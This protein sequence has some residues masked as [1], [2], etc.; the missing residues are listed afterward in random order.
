MNPAPSVFD[1]ATRSILTAARR[2][3]LGAFATLACLAN[4]QQQ[5]QGVCAQAK[6]EILQELTFERIGFEATLE[7]TNNLGGDPITDF[8]AELYF[9]DPND[10][11]DS[12]PRDVSDRFF[13]QRPRLTDINAVDG[14]GLIG[15]TKTAIIRWFIVPK[16]DAGGENPNGKRYEVGVR[17][18]G[19]V[20][21]VIL[22]KNVLVAIPDTIVVR[23]EPQLDINYF[24][25]RDVQGDDPFTDEVE[26]AVPFTLG[27]LVRN[28][29]FGTARNLKIAS[30]Q[31]K[32]IENTAG[33][34]LVAQLLGSR[35][36]DS[37]LDESSLTVNLGD[38][39]P[40]QT[41]KGAW[42]M[43]TTLSGEFTEFKAS[44]T[45]RDDLGGE[46]TSLIKS[47][48]AHFILRE[49]INNDPGR[50]AIM[51][52]IADVDRDENLLPDTLYES[53]GQVLPINH[54]PDSFVST[55][56]SGLTFQVTVNALAEGWG[57]ARLADPGQAKYG[58]QSAVRSD[59]R[60]VHPRNI[61]TNIRY[62][63]GTNAKL[64]FLNIFDKFPSPGTYT[65]T[66]TYAPPPADTTP[67]ETRLRF[68]GEVTESGG[69]FYITP[70]TQL[71]FTSDDASPVSIFYR[72]N[73][74]ADVPGLPFTISLPGETLIEYYAS[75]AAGNVEVRKS[76]IVVLPGSGPVLA[77]VTA[78]GDA[79]A[80]TEDVLTF[81]PDLVSLQITAGASGVPVTAQVDVFRG[82]RSWPTLRG[83]PVTPTPATTATITV[84]GDNVD[85]YRY[86]VNGGA[87]SAERAVSLPFALT[88]LD[89]NVSV[90]VV[91]RS[92]HAS[93]P[94]DNQA[95]TATWTVDPAAAEWLLGGLPE[96]PTRV[97][98]TT[99]TVASAGLEKYRWR[100]A[101]SFYRA[102]AD[103]SEALNFPGQNPGTQT[104]ELIARRS[105]VW[106]DEEEP[107]RWSWTY[108][109]AHGSD[110]SS[111][112]LVRTQTFPSVQGSSFT[113]NWDGRS[114]VGVPQ[115][116]GWYTVRIR[117]E[118]SL[119]N[120]DFRTVLVRVDDVAGVPET[121]A[122]VSAG[123]ERPR[124][125]GDWLVW[126]ERGSGSPN[127]RAR[128]ASNLGPVLEITNTSLAQSHPRTD[129]RWVVW[130][131]Q[132]ADGTWDIYITDLTN[133][134]VNTN[135]TESP[136]ADETNP[137]ID[138]PWVVWQAR[139]TTLPQATWQVQAYN[140]TT[141]QAIGASVSTK[142][143]IDPSVHAGR[144][145]WQDFRDVGFGEIYMRDLEQG[146][147][148]RLT[149]NSFGQYSPAIWG[150]WVV[151]QDNRHTQVELY[152]M[153][154]LRG[155]E[156]R[157]TNTGFNEADPRMEGS[158]V[159]Y[160]EDSVGVL[161][162]NFRLL[163]LDTLRSVPLTRSE[164][165]KRFGALSGH[166]LFWQ[167]GSGAST[168]LQRASIPGLQPVFRNNN[169]VLVTAQV[170]ANFGSVQALLA[171]WYS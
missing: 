4:A 83:V 156:Q 137:D 163:D 86:R 5:F 60:V 112:P 150:N 45:H 61:W 22:P 99:L 138:W 96:T 54:A 59:G 68:A 17:M 8:S 24:Q 69:K 110:F 82:I 62:E 114:G 76:A 165:S 33:L 115:P 71:Y 79:L 31:P 97:P 13:V 57:Y 126:S 161:T 23:P 124:S 117:I 143:Q 102:E 113:F 108:D 47:L 19:K 94:P 49:G 81:R 101:G 162:G 20:S 66:I 147:I 34:L 39:G 29:G 154:L 128:R 32:I 153:N 72:L 133:P 151:W 51:D 44:Y 130:Q 92:Q 56:L 93:F 118:D 67:P 36:Q 10:L 43:I 100:P 132:Q 55:P 64:T 139:S 2:V 75:D 164:S 122:A 53:E 42:D 105:G 52:F 166:Q 87:W 12:V 131:G 35:V 106:Q 158:R 155:V 40:G 120:F 136:E 144:V 142:D 171:H 104:L 25:P 78:S 160:A 169:T 140:L 135:I 116:P 3:L 58:F 109:P 28:S 18:A 77:S 27:V 129:G 65:Y 30:Q 89:G 80:M 121:L 95:V 15:P 46:S 125:R 70:A 111:L 107:S 103:P 84:G 134:L 50:D 16:P 74:G 14:T 41:R 73:G 37:P 11:I 141:A 38:I 9:R 157:L 167:G 149:Q 159:L 88:G 26:S 63:R 123:P 168:T 148:R 48:G 1:M 170:A 146:S 21:G 90:Q 98:L 145:V 127:I 7:I 85:F 6:V 152:G 91:G 119:G